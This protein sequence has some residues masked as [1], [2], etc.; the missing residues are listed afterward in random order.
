MEVR[1]PFTS[2][3]VHKRLAKVNKI[4]QTPTAITPGK[5]KKK[6]IDYYSPCIDKVDELFSKYV[7]IFCEFKSGWVAL[8]NLRQLLKHGVP[9][10]V[11]K[12]SCC[13]FH[14]G[15]AQW[16]H[17]R[18]HVVTLGLSGVNPL[19]LQ[20]RPSETLSNLFPSPIKK[21]EL[22]PTYRHVRP[23]SGVSRF[24]NRVH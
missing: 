10:G 3:A 13:Q 14:Q 18:P 6:K 15:D 8:N 9:F 22:N 19:R 1:F 5:T 23:T 11:R 2:I 21:G 7:P 4:V 17:I 24:G 20:E 12:R 16:P